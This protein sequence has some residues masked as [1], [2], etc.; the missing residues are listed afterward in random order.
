MG[1]DISDLR[2]TIRFQISDLQVR[3][4]AK[5]VDDPI[6]FHQQMEIYRAMEQSNLVTT[7]RVKVSELKEQLQALK[8]QLDT[9]E[10]QLRKLEDEERDKQHPNKKQEQPCASSNVPNLPG[11]SVRKKHR[12]I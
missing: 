9:A 3:V 6:S 8:N 2:D 10:G 1:R 12:L 7:Q 11:D 4:A 5:T